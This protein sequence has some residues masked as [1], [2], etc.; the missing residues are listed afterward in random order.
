M[1]QYQQGTAQWNRARLQETVVLRLDPMGPFNQTRTWINNHI[2]TFYLLTDIL[3]EPA[4]EQKLCMDEKL[5]HADYIDVIT[6][7]C[8]CPDGG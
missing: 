2:H 4:V 1:I 7:I 5:H 3:N 6:Y 8:P